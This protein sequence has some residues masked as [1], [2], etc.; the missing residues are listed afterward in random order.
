MQPRASVPVC[1][2][3]AGSWKRISADGSGVVDLGQIARS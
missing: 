2:G 3:N 1:H